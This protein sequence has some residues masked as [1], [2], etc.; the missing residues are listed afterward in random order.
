MKAALLGLV[1]VGLGLGLAASGCSAAGAPVVEEETSE[2]SELVAC[3]AVRGAADRGA[4]TRLWAGVPAAWRGVLAAE[5]RKAYFPELA[6]FVAQAR[7]G[8]AA[9]FPCEADTFTALMLAGPDAVQVVILGQDPYIKPGQAHGLAFSV[10]PPTAPPPSLRNILKELQADVPAITPVG[11]GSLEQ[12]AKQGVLLLNSVLTVEEG[13]S[14]SHACKGWETFTDAIIASVSARREPVVFVLWG[15]FAQSKTP[16]IDP[17]HVV[18]QSAHPSPLSAHRGFLGS[19]PFSKVNAA[20]EAL[21]KRP[22][23]WQLPAQPSSSSISQR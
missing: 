14:G 4:A 5:R 1:L 6:R 3:G 23:D 16:L 12:W 15:S 13:K 21:S 8:E 17:R 22:I 11:H 18:I 9:V 10:K 7:A 2:E 20:L 19:R